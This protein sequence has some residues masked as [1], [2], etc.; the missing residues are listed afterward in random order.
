MI[1]ENDFLNILMDNTHDNI[2]FKDKNSRFIRINKH[3]ATYF[4]LRDPVEVIG[5]SDH[6]FFSSERADLC[7][8]DERNIL[9]TGEP[10]IGL[11]E[12]E[13]WPDGKISWVNTTKQ[14]LLDQEG[15]IIGT[16]GISRD[17]TEQKEN[18]DALR[19]SE[20]DYKALF[21]NTL[22]GLLVIEAETLSIIIANQAAAD[23]FDAPSRESMSGF[24]PF[25]FIHPED[26]PS[27]KNGVL[28]HDQLLQHVFDC[29][30]KTAKRE[31]WVNML[32]SKII[33][34]GKAAFLLAIRD[35]SER[36]KAE[37][38]LRL[39][40]SR[41]SE[42]LA[43]LRR[44]QKQLV[45]RERMSALGQMASGIAHDFNNS[46]TPILGYSQMLASDPALL[47]NKANA[48]EMLSDIYRAAKTATASI[49]RLREFYRPD[50][51]PLDSLVDINE[52][53]TQAI[54]LT[55]PR[56]KE[57]MSAKGCII[58]VTESLGAV[59]KIPGNAAQLCQV[60]TNLIL[61]SVNAIAGEGEGLIKI[62]TWADNRQV[63][64]EIMDTGIGM[65]EETKEHCF[66]P[67]F[68][69]KK[70]QGSGM[71]MAVAHGIIEQHHGAIEVDSE[72]GEGATIIFKLP[73]ATA[74]QQAS[75]NAFDKCAPVPP[76]RVL[77]IDDDPHCLRVIRCFLE[78]D[79]HVAVTTESGKDGLDTFRKG[80]FD[81]VITD[82]SLLDMS[83]DDVAATIKQINKDIP[84]IMLSGFGDIMMAENDI[85]N[86][87]D[88]VVSKPVDRNELDNAIRLVRVSPVISI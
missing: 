10:I 86:G 33:Y 81:L 35:I 39:A 50:E 57:E 40:K 16:F 64:V 18:E 73:Q 82:R 7:L 15:K 67:F 44:T 8:A 36:K 31:L 77:L 87:V 11:V 49:R 14:P 37:E 71:G 1:T 4:G 29:R 74:A 66:E 34:R 84:I 47:D 88:L 59:P 17:I 55:Q 58:T 54:V 75:A 56:W 72:P 69:T 43:E 2:Y 13:V 65:T 85:P 46:L 61:N 79:K 9:K 38:A 21:E 6:D 62:S 76:L 24:N 5:K 27:V 23:I 83:G 68:T 60:I 25:N 48:M 26:I 45:Q 53:V 20:N 30:V 42:A 32:C 22:D 70:N 41:R 19:Q 63:I 80:K 78:A 52:V 3:L 12:K 51:R 28:S